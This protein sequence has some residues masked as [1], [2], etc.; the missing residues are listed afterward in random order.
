MKLVGARSAGL[1]YHQ[2]RTS[3][4]SENL[5]VL[6]GEEGTGESPALDALAVFYDEGVVRRAADPVFLADGNRNVPP[7]RDV[8]PAILS[9]AELRSSIQVGGRRRSARGWTTPRR[10]RHQVT[11]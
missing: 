4:R 1:R 3:F 5:M 9:L 7:E 10:A 8:E 6:L 2:T 11:S